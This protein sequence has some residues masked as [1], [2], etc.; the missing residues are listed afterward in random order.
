VALDGSRLLIGADSVGD[1]A[2]YIFRQ[3]AG[4]AAG[5]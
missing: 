3:S 4:S 2:A 1:G 5:R